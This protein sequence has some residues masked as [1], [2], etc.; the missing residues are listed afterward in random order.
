MFAAVVMVPHAWGASAQ[1]TDPVSEYRPVPAESRSS[2]D[3]QGLDIAARVVLGDRTPVEGAVV[4]T[5]AGGRGVTDAQGHARVR[6]TVDAGGQD[7]V[8][9]LRVTAAATLDGRTLVGSATVPDVSDSAGIV[10]MLIVVAPTATCDPQWLPTFGGRPGVAGRVFDL[11]VFDDG[12][13][14]V[15]YAAGPL[16]ASNPGSVITNNIA[17][18]D[19]HSWAAVGEGLDGGPLTTAQALAV[20]DDGDGPALYVGGRFETAGGVPARSIARWDGSQWSAVGPGGGIDNDGIVTTLGVFDDGTGPALY[21]G[22]DFSSVDGGL[23]T[24]NLARWDGQEWSGVGGGTNNSI[25]AFEVFDDGTGPGLYVGGTFNQAGG[26]TASRIA[27]WD[28]QS[29]S[30][31]RAIINEGVNNSVLSM[32][33]YDDGTGPALIVGGFFTIAGDRTARRVARWNGSV[34]SAVGDGFDDGAV[35]A[36]RMFDDG[37][38]P[39]LYAGGTFTSAEGEPARFIARFDGVA[40]SSFGDELSATNP[41][42]GVNAL[43]AFQ[44]RLFAGGDFQSVGDLMSQSIT[45]WDGDRWS[46]VG[47]G[48]N[49]QVFALEVFDDGTGP[50][51]YA[52]GTFDIVASQQVG[53]IARWDGTSWT[54][55]GDGLNGWVWDLEVFDDGTGPALYAGGS[56]TTFDD[57]PGN[58]IARWDGTTWSP[59]GGGGDSTVFALEVFDEGSGPVLFAGGLFRFMGGVSVDFIARWD[60]SQWSAVGDEIPGTDS[61]VTELT[62]FDDGSGPALYAGGLFAFAGEERANRVARWDGQEWSGLGSGMNG[63]VFALAGFD[64]GTGPALFAGGDFS[65]ADGRPALRLARWDGSEWSSAGTV[66]GGVFQTVVFHL[67]VFDDGSGPALYAGGDFESIG[68]VGATSIARW[69][70]G[71]EWESLDSGMDHA[72]QVMTTFDDG[73]GPALFVGGSFSASLSGDSHLAKFAGCTA[74]CT[75]DIDRDGVLDASDFFAYLNLF[76]TGSDAADLD[77]DGLIDA[78]DFFEYLTLFAAGCP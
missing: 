37:N 20:F 16:A 9:T 18:W 49:E 5:T 8:Q 67:E 50:A 73:S 29:W 23:P 52:A 69:D 21:V 76:A 33:V 3:R 51:L 72:V 31:L 24:S 10:D 65:T 19:G 59:V 45:A 43:V 47:L 78:S 38:G 2:D 61:T 55:V 48:P 25:N 44:G 41:T 1:P 34:W 70:G 64:D 75:P 74:P 11:A 56:F 42:P 26:V 58:F 39:R 22:G 17:R 77:G 12:S 46:T 13:G 28:G 57:G 54:R 30:P 6:A 14:P 36:L 32:T 7:V 63:V 15:L 62:V 66:L 71:E 60:G 68:G 4:V 35:R 40:W 53:Y 27:R